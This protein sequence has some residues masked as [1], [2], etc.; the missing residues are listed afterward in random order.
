MARFTLFITLLA[1]P[2]FANDCYTVILSSQWPAWHRGRKLEIQNGEAA[3]FLIDLNK[4]AA[5]HEDRLLTRKIE[6]LPRKLMGRSAS[7]I[8]RDDV[9]LL[10]PQNFFGFINLLSADKIRN[11]WDEGKQFPRHSLERKLWPFMNPTGFFQKTIRNTI[12]TQAKDF[13]NFLHSILKKKDFNT[14]STL[15]KISNYLSNSLGA[16]SEQVSLIIAALATKTADELKPF[17]KSWAVRIENS[18][19]LVVTAKPEYLPSDKPFQQNI[20]GLVAVGNY[21]RIRVSVYGGE[22]PQEAL[23][24]KLPYQN[25]A[26]K[27]WTVG[28]IAIHTVDDIEVRV[29]YNALGFILSAFR[30]II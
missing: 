25:L 23:A 20:F 7:I 21:H 1:L 5:G 12:A 14:Q 3:K 9:L 13:S 16:N 18:N 4:A 27:I 11:L 22:A 17:L 2:I 29:D 28:I 24:L 8:L 15:E 6:I 30:H 19:N 26:A 10:T